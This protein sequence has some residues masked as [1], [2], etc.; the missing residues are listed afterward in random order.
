MAQNERLSESLMWCESRSDTAATSTT[1][2]TTDGQRRFERIARSVMN[3]NRNI[4]V[5]IT[6]A[7]Y[8]QFAAAVTSIAVATVRGSSEVQTAS[9]T[10][11]R[12]SNTTAQATRHQRDLQ[13]HPYASES[14]IALQSR[15]SWN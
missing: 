1:K 8:G 11:Q 12:P 13:S 7:V 14:C 10:P 9:E 4:A 6:R 2:H 3:I 15:I 5:A